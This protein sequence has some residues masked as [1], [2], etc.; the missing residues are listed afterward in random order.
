MTFT[1]SGEEQLDVLTE[2][3]FQNAVLRYDVRNESR[4]G[5]IK[6]VVA[7]LYLLERQLPAQKTGDF[8]A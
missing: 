1:F 2:R 6:T 3:S 5:N 4:G 7:A 8:L